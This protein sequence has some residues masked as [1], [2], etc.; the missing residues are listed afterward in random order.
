MNVI[1]EQTGSLPLHFINTYGTNGK[2]SK[3]EIYIGKT[4]VPVQ[5]FDDD[6]K[7]LK[8]EFY[9]PN[10]EG[11]LLTTEIFIYDDNGNFSESKRS[12][13]DSSVDI[14]WY[15]WRKLPSPVIEDDDDSEF[16]CFINSIKGTD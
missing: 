12:N 2:L 14:K 4:L 5:T 16:S 8:R 7:L 6:E 15:T 11:E 3:Q 1:N 9:S 10:M 13:S